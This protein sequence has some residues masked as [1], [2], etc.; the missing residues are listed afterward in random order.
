MDQGSATQIQSITFPDAQWNAYSCLNFAMCMDAGQNTRTSIV[1]YHNLRELILQ[2][3][4]GHTANNDWEEYYGLNRPMGR[5]SCKE[6]WTNAFQREQ[7]A[8]PERKIPN[9]IFCLPGGYE[10][11]NPIILH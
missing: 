10:A 9:I 8:H 2:V 6:L 4:D 3:R 7:Q 5:E 1:K 11:S